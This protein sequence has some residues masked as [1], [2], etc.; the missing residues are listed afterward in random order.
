MAPDVDPHVDALLAED[1]AQA[2]GGVLLLPGTLADH[3]DAAVAAVFLREGMVGGHVGQVVH[4]AVQVDEL[5]RVIA[6]SVAGSIDAAQGEQAV[7]QVRTA[8]EAVCGVRRA[9][10]AAEGD[11]AGIARPA[12]A[13]VDH[14]AG[15]GN[16]FVENIGHPLL[17]PADAPVGVVIGAPGFAVHR[18][19]GEDHYPPRV[20]PGLPH[21][22]HVEVLKVEEAPVLA[23]D[24]K[25]RPSGVAVDLHLHVTVQGRAV[26]LEI[27]CFHRQ[28]LSI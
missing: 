3:D 15:E 13:R 19:D 2:E 8:E 9:E 18:V 23:G 17:M 20:D 10:R 12:I 26:L 24:E 25:H 6:E 5:V 11:H 7:E 4:R 27:L 1:V 21:V 28:D 22:R 16:D 14:V